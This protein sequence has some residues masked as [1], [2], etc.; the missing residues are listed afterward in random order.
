MKAKTKIDKEIFELKNKLKKLTKKEIDYVK[1]KLFKYYYTISRNRFFCLACGNKDVL[2]TRISNKEN[3]KCPKCSKQL[4][5]SEYYNTTQ[6]V[7]TVRLEVCNEYQVVRYFQHWQHTSLKTECRIWHNEVIQYWILPNGKY[8]MLAKLSSMYSRDNFRDALAPRTDKDIHRNVCVHHIFAKEMLPII[9]RNGYSPNNDDELPPTATILNLLKDNKF[10]TLYKMR[11]YELAYKVI[12]GYDLTEWFKQIMIC[13]RHNYVI[14]DF[15]T[16]KDYLGQLQYFKKDLNNPKYLCPPNLKEAHDHWVKKK[17]DH[18]RRLKLQELRATMEN[19]NIV[20][21]QEKHKLLDLVLTKDGVTLEPLKD[22][23][24]FFNYSHIFENCLFENEY[25]KKNDL[26]IF[27]VKQEDKPKELC[28]YDL[29]GMYI[30]QISGVNNSDSKLKPI[31]ETI[32]K[33][34]KSLIKKTIKQAYGSI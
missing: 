17:K 27:C 2:T 12:K 18:T 21:Q 29:E 20:Y 11:Q 5:Y 25:Y 30:Q 13:I 8:S 34:N 31:V 28:A 6:V 22:V 4:E 1:S 10:E 9:A 23:Q 3:I 32:F 14:S 16:W 7:Y 19:D 15:N 26:L 33:K 24:S